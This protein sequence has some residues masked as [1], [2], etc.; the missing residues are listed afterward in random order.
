[1]P[2]SV[3]DLCKI[4]DIT[5]TDT[6]S[7]L[8]AAPILDGDRLVLAIRTAVG[9]RLQLLVWR[10]QQPS[11]VLT[12]LAGSGT[13]AGKASSIAIAKGGLYVTAFRTEAGN[14]KL[15]SW[16][17]ATNG[18]ITRRGDS[19]DQAGSASLIRI[20]AL[21]FDMFL[22][23]SRTSE[24]RLK[25][26]AWRVGSDGRIS[27][28]ADGATTSEQVAEH[29]LVLHTPRAGAGGGRVVTVIRTTAGPD[30][31]KLITWDVTSTGVVTRLRDSGGQAGA[32]TLV[33]VTRDIH[34]SIVSAARVGFDV[35]VV[36]WRMGSDGSLT[37]AGE[38]RGY[39]L[40]SSTQALLAHPDGVVCATGATGGGVNLAGFSTDATGGVVHRSDTAEQAGAGTRVDLVATN[41]TTDAA[42]RRISTIALVQTT[43]GNLRVI[44]W[45][46]ACVRLHIKILSDP[47]QP[48][49]TLLAQMQELYGSA[50]IRVQ[51]VSTERLTLPAL[52]DI[53]VGGCTSDDLTEEQEQ[54]FGHRNGVG[55]GEIVVY[56]VRSID[57]LANGCA[58]HPEGRPGAVVARYGT[59]HTLGHE[60]GHVLGLGH[61]NNDDR[62][63]TGNGTGNI[64]NPPPDLIGEEASQ[65]QR[66][67]LTNV[68]RQA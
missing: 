32:G 57:P 20:V 14:L 29:D 24:G 41:G 47:N 33:R 2:S 46:P 60:V 18:T 13:Q 23:A 66:S 17:V 19:G 44:S 67:S 50:G 26:I 11:G 34:G 4:S 63:M 65:M 52:E 9:G 39:F 15:V 56:F 37:R 43:T 38:S 21:T 61:V 53:D 36:V 7:E 12:R 1:M 51:H 62:L 6:V 45:G 5:S 48:I 16:Q 68:C 42:G 31:I 8:V 28:L 54:L 10:V 58:A 35:R 40:S 64:T 30:A 3:L 22:T 25:L 27:R 49:E 55:A 59:L